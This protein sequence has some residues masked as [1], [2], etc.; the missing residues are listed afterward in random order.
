[1]GNDKFILSNNSLL[2][3]KS[4]LIILK[5]DYIKARIINKVYLYKTTAYLSR[6]KIKVLLLT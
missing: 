1:K 5:E 4:R 3:Y 2:L 6:N